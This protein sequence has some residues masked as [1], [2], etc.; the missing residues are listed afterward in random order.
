[1]KE[2]LASSE[3]AP[4]LCTTNC[5]A[6]E[7]SRTTPRKPEVLWASARIAESTFARDKSAR[8][9][10]EIAAFLPKGTVEPRLLSSVVEF[11]DKA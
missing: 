5:A 3:S 4:G 6:M 9:F 1:M 2:Q 8:R 7:S 11:F 10:R